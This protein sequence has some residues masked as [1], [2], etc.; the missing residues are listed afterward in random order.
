MFAKTPT[1]NIFSWSPMSEHI[2]ESTDESELSHELVSEGPIKREKVKPSEWTNDITAINRKAIKKLHNKGL[3]CSIYPDGLIFPNGDDDVDS[4]E[5]P[6]FNIGQQAISP[7]KLM[8]AVVKS[9]YNVKEWEKE[10]KW[11]LTRFTKSHVQK[12]DGI[13]VSVK[14]INGAE[15]YKTQ[16]NPEKAV[17]ALFNN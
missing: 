12:V 13:T 4:C 7:K 17:F 9:N 16:R 11:V 5:S 14:D 10:M 2:S 8:A 1:N 15:C 3:P 6:K